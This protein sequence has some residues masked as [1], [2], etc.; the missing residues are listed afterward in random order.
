MQGSRVQGS[1]F[2]GIWVIVIV[3]QVLGKYMNMTDLDHPK[4]PT[5]SPE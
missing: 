1:R 2:W 4:A 3:G 5:K